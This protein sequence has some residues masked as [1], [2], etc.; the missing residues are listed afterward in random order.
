MSM[1]IGVTA[2]LSSSDRDSW[3]QSE[4]GIRKGAVMIGMND[5][6]LVLIEDVLNFGLFPNVGYFLTDNIVL[7]GDP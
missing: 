3:G 2:F 5:S 6:Y 4:S 7:G 1:T